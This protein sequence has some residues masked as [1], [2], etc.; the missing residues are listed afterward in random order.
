MIRRVCSFSA[1]LAI[2]VTFAS[3]QAGNLHLKEHVSGVTDECDLL[4]IATHDFDGE[5]RD[6]RSD[7][8]AE[9]FSQK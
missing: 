2:C 7:A 4:R 1:L 3:V 8:G 6:N 5:V 9:Q